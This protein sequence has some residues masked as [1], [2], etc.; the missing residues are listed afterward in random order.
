MMRVLYTRECQCSASGSV[1]M[2]GEQENV[3]M[4]QTGGAWSS[5][6]RW[7]G[8][9]TGESCASSV[10]VPVV[11]PGTA[12]K[13][14]SPGAVTV[15]D[16]G[17]LRKAPGDADS[18]STARSLGREV[19]LALA[20]PARCR[21]GKGCQCAAATGGTLN[22]A[23]EGLN[24]QRWLHRGGSCRSGSA[25]EGRCGPGKAGCWRCL[26]GVRAGDVG[27]RGSYRQ[28]Q[29]WGTVAVAL[30]VRLGRDRSAGSAA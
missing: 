10:S 23:V 12:W 17:T 3:E 7:T 16:P 14:A 6:V 9:A 2:H 1:A 20:A 19:R 29:G 25:L 24:I 15:A 13:E 27:L 21:P 18:L 8:K 5:S 26:K 11:R 28:G 22:A 30:T 4:Q